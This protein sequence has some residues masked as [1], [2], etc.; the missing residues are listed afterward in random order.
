MELRADMLS[1]KNDSA[2]KIDIKLADPLQHI[3]S[4][5]PGL[6]EL[7][8][9]S[10][11][12]EAR[13][14]IVEQAQLKMLTVPEFLRKSLDKLDEISEPIILNMKNLRPS[15]QNK[16]REAGTWIIS[17]TIEF[18]S[19]CNSLLLHF[20]LAYVLKRYLQRYATVITSVVGE[21]RIDN[22]LSVSTTT[23]CCNIS[24]LS[25]VTVCVGCY[26]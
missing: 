22:R 19:F 25:T 12:S 23:S 3:F 6:A 18:C 8:H 7:P 15:I 24:T 14:K 20:G 5:L 17:V 16:F 11:M 4:K 26:S 9:I 13:R 10:S 2:K 1:C 21:K